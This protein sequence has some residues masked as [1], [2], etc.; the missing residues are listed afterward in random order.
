MTELNIYKNEERT[1]YIVPDSW[2]DITIEKFQLLANA[3]SE[4][5]MTII[6]ILVRNISLLASIPEDILYKLS[7][8]NFQLIADCFKFLDT[9]IIDDFKDEIEVEGEIY[10]M[11]K[12]F[13]DLNFGESV[14]I[15]IMMEKSGNN[16]MKCMDILLSIFL[17]KK[18]ENGELEEYDT[19]F[20]DRI[21]LFS[22]IK[23]T[24]V[25]QLFGFFLGLK[26]P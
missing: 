6:E 2:N 12:D 3:G 24:D 18:L 16:I 17:R 26:K 21:E 10:Y 11:K 20:K 13:K 15:D 9:E 7:P 8:Q 14:S 5:D 23:I 25:Y 19:K 22:Q 4:D 1:Q